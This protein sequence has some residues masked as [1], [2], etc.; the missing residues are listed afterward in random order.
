MLT[1]KL[2]CLRSSTLAIEE[3]SGSE[4]R[5]AVMIPGNEIVRVVRGPTPTDSRMVDVVWKGRQLVMFTVDI[6]SRGK[7]VQGE[8]A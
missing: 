3:A 1:G 8:S 2:F 7:E 6:E 5:I 4:H